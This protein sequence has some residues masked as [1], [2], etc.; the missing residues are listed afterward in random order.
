M[1]DMDMWFPIPSVQYLADLISG[2]KYFVHFYNNEKC[3]IATYAFVDGES[4]R[5]ITEFIDVDGFLQEVNELYNSWLKKFYYGVKAAV[6]KIRGKDPKELAL[7]RLDDFIKKDRLPN[8]ASIK[9]IVGRAITEG[10]YER[11]LI[12]RPNMD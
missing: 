1:G 11:L 8:G 9:E 7:E 2:R 3:G 12:L 10:S 5:P 4:L 6:A